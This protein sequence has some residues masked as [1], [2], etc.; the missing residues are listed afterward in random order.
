MYLAPEVL[1][2][3]RY[4]QK[5]DVYS[6]AMVFYELLTLNKPFPS[7]ASAEAHRDLVG[8]RG[9]RPPL[10][11][12]NIPKPIQRLLRDAWDDNIISRLTMR[13]V[14]QRLEQLPAELEREAAAAEAKL[15]QH[16]PQATGIFCG[17]FWDAIFGFVSDV[18]CGYK[19]LT[20]ATPFP[21]GKLGLQDDSSNSLLVDS[22]RQETPARINYMAGEYHDLMGNETEETMNS[23]DSYF[24]SRASWHLNPVLADEESKEVVFGE[25]ARTAV[26]EFQEAE[27]AREDHE[28]IETYEEQRVDGD[29]E[30]SGDMELRCPASPLA[31]TASAPQPQRRTSL[32]F[33]KE[34]AT[35]PYHAWPASVEVPV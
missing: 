9:A 2:C 18:Q 3:G 32:T 31:R 8:K 4:N 15:S 16:P 5:A 23:S 27:F 20:K 1:R 7:M 10:E 11:H 12:T 26:L 25:E 6:F 17:S 34:Q 28:E 30:P 22:V 14:C 33:G 24:S 29:H 35:G 13:Q 21:G 19:V